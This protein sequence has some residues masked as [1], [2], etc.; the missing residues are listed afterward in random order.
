MKKVLLSCIALAVGTA[1]SLAQEVNNPDLPTY[2]STLNFTLNGEKELPGV[3]VSQ[4]MV[5]YDGSECLTIDITGE[6]DANVITMDFQTPDGWDYAL[7]DSQIDGADSPFSTR[8][9]ESD[10]WVA[11]KD[12]M[13]Y[14][15]GNYFKFPV[16][17]KQCYA[18][19]YLVKGDNV[20]AYPIDIT[21]KFTKIEGT[22]KDPN[23]LTLPEALEYTLNGEKELTG[24]K[25]KQQIDD[26]YHLINIT[27]ECDS[28]K[29]TVSFATPKGWDG[30]MIADFYGYGEITTVETRSE[31]SLIP[32]EN[33]LGMGFKE[34]NT[35]TFE[36]DGEANIGY[37]AL[38]KGDMVCSTFI[39]FDITVGNTNG[40]DDPIVV[41]APEFPTS[42]GITT[43]ANG[44]EVW[45]G[46]EYDILTIRLTGEIEEETFDVVLDV[47]EGWDGFVSL[48]SDE[49]IVIGE[50]GIGPRKTRAEEPY[51][52][53]IDE[54]IDWGAEKGNKFTFT[55][56]GEK[57]DVMIYLYKD[58]MVDVANWISLENNEVKSSS[59]PSA[60]E[61]INVNDVNSAYFDMN[62]RK[63]ANP[64]KGVY[65]KVAD[66]KAKKIVVK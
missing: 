44:L 31:L 43:Y 4:T 9:K 2:P 35:I 15:E 41:D 21:A 16:N 22:E 45:Q 26:T 47:P 40:S 24:I 25:V 27:G 5:P 60:V 62:G 32:I 61:G 29:I 66:G 1:M 46:E 30:L 3:S 36:T 50:S 14:K 57:Q 18:T 65:V 33:I 28:D 55:P 63:I 23:A 48:P 20:W 17:G 49:S 64:A 56:N 53:E 11:V 38:V 52:I 42:V 19:I 37:I 12:V 39:D 51:W 54:V 8:S 58:G 6:Y 34:G 10:S 59:D 13:G 7:I